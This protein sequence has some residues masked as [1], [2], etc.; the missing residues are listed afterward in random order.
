MLGRKVDCAV[1]CDWAWDNKDESAIPEAV[2]LAKTADKI[3]LCFGE[4]QS[5]SGECK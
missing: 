4:H 1:G 2:E 5:E 3:V